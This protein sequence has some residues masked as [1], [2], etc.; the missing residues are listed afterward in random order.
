MKKSNFSEQQ[1][2]AILKRW[3]LDEQCATCREHQVSEATYYKWK[4]NTEVWKQPTFGACESWKKKIAASST[5][6]L[7]SPWNIAS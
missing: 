1:I 7:S 6:T 5:C 3:K 2:I 4:T